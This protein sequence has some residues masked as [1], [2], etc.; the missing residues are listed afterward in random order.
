MATEPKV[1]VS[2]TWTIEAPGQKPKTLTL[3]ASDVGGPAWVELFKSNVRRF[4]R[5]ITK[6]ALELTSAP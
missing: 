6:Q 1:K 2:V 3:R 4:T 5:A